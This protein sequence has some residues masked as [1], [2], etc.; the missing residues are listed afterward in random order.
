MSI[1]CCALHVYWV[2]RQVEQAVHTELWKI[3]QRPIAQQASTVD[4]S[5][6]HSGSA[7]LSGLCAARQA[8]PRTRGC[9]GR[10]STT[11]WARCL[12]CRAWAL[13]PAS[14]ARRRPRRSSSRSLLLCP[15]TGL[16]SS[17]RCSG[18]MSRLLCRVHRL[19][20]VLMAVAHFRPTTSNCCLKPTDMNL[21]LAGQR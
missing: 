9:S 12:P 21:A 19:E 8:W 16:S 13:S 4:V 3:S 14:S 11:A 1:V 5:W 2:A 15:W 7:S 17:S 18:P 6:L 20:V 10:P